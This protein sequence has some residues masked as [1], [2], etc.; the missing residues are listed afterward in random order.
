MAIRGK[1]IVR[2]RGTGDGPFAVL[3]RNVPDDVVAR[4]LENAAAQSPKLWAEVRW[5]PEM[6]DE[7]AP[8]HVFLAGQYTTTLLAQAQ[9]EG[10]NCTLVDPQNLIRVRGCEARFDLRGDDLRLEASEHRKNDA[11]ALE[12]AWSGELFDFRRWLERPAV[13]APHLRVVEGSR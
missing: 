2:V 6:G 8:V 7:D 4:V 3:F 12:E 1:R 10:L 5:D 11:G 9:I 13:K